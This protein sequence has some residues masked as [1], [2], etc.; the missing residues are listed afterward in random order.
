[1][2]L[3]KIKL[4]IFCIFINKDSTL[5]KT[6]SGR[7]FSTSETD[8]EWLFPSVPEKLKALHD[9]GYSIVIFSNQMGIEKN[10]VP[11]K[12]LQNKI[13]AMIDSAKVPIIT[14]L[15]S[16]IDE[17]RKPLIGMFNLFEE[18]VTK[19][20][21]ATSFFVGDAAGRGDGWKT[22]RKKDI[23]CGDRK[24]ASNVG[25][26][27]QT[28]EE[29]FLGEEEAPFSWGALD[30]KTV[31]TTGKI[32]ENPDN[33][34][35][36]TQEIIVLVGYPA[37]GKSTFAKTYLLPN[38]YAHVNRDTLGT[39]H[40]CK[41]AATDALEAK[42]SVVIDGPNPNVEARSDWVALAR[43]FQVPIRCYQLL[44]DLN[45]AKHLNTVRAVTV[46]GTKPI[47][48]GVYNVFKSKFQ[49]PKTS[50]GFTEVKK[51]QFIR[52]HPDDNH[53]QIFEMWTEVPR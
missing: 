8:W 29:Y 7:I 35:S 22:G 39:I 52:Q 1:M 43:Q 16:S 44:T 21:K 34:I 15:A 41:S 45:L 9:D 27:F 18:L 13:D 33:I 53:R 37:S 20:D 23:S 14:F 25:L 51:I 31:P 12:Q 50:E 6:K 48:S 47:S 19:V 11:V 32:T 28:P 40:K 36:S 26:P 30:P 38:G 24:F 17:Y 2:Y 42:Q 10:Q 3:L 46:T 49:E 5:I 4:L